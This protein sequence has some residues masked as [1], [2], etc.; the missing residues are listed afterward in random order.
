VQYSLWYNAHNM[1]PAGGMEA[2]LLH[3]QILYDLYPFSLLMVFLMAH[4][5]LG[6]RRQGFLVLVEWNI[7]V[8][9]VY[10]GFFLIWVKLIS[11]FNIII[12]LRCF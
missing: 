7:L 5:R 6:L 12:W 2:E 8:V 4:W 9:R 1:W 3:L 11:G 10:I